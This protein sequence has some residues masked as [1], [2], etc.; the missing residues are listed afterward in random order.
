MLQY[1]GDAAGSWVEEIEE[2]D[3]TQECSAC[4]AR[5][6][7]KGLTG[8]AVRNWTCVCGAVHDRDVNSAL[9]IKHRGLAGLAHRD[10]PDRGRTRKSPGLRQRRE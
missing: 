2:Y 1:K 8:L 10:S 7:P 9:N 4:H 5:T 6:G 3:S